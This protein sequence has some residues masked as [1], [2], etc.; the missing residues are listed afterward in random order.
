MMNVILRNMGLHEQICTSGRTQ[1]AFGCLAPIRRYNWIPMNKCAN[2][3]ARRQTQPSP[4][5][6]VPAQL[7]QVG[8]AGSLK[9]PSTNDLDSLEK[10]LGH[11]RNV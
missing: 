9:F 11:H 3:W 5:P 10:G 2:V 4:G 7:S 8:S 6:P 1:E